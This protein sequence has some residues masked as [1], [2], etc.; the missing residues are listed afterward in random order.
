MA[1]HWI[2]QSTLGDLNLS[3]LEQS[4]AALMSGFREIEVLLLAVDF[5]VE[6]S[7][8]SALSRIAATFGR[9]DIAVNNAGISGSLSPTQNFSR[10]R[11]AG[12]A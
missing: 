9:L 10:E 12:G 6:A 4:E 8:D 1:K 11:M 7:I 2:R 5:V 3:K